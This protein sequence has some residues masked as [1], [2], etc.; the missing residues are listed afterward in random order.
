MGMLDNMSGSIYLWLAIAILVFWCVGLYNR[1]TRMRDRAGAAFGSLEKHL[2]TFDVLLNAYAMVDEGSVAAREQTGSLAG[3]W[4]V[5]KQKVLELERASK[6]ARLA[7]LQSL[8]M[9]AMSQAIDAVLSEWHLI[10]TEPADL[11]G[12]PVPDAMRIQWDD[13]SARAQSARAAL[14]QIMQRY[15]DALQE[16]PARFIVGIL[17]FKPAGKL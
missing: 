5:L 7:Q 2:K 3:E 12:S 14:N 9:E 10:S 8:P 17:G 16:F 15:N 1:I 6:A 13:A 11:A 4:L